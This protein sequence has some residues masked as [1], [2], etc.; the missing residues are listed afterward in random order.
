[1][2]KENFQFQ[3]EVSRLLDLVTHS[4]YSEK[5]IF[6]REL[7][8]NSSDACDKMRYIGLTDAQKLENDTQF[9]VKIILNKDDK[10]LTIS[11]N[12]IGMSRQDLIDHLGTIAQSGTAKFLETLNDSKNAVQLIGQFGVGFY[13]AFIVASEVHVHSRKAGEDKAYEWVS[14]GKGA[15]TIEEKQKTNRGTDVV[16]KLKEGEEGYLEF[17]Y[18][19]EII[20]KYSDHIAIPIVLMSDKGEEQLNK[21]SALWT[22]PKADITTEEYKEFY[23]HIAHLYDEPWDRLHFKAEG[24]IEYAALLYIPSERPMDLFHPDRKHRV[25]L[26]VKRVF[27]TDD[28]DEL[29][30][31]Y[32]RFLKGVID[33]DDLPLNISREM[34]QKNPVLAKIRQNVTK[35]V[36][37]ELQKKSENLEDYTKFWTSFGAVLK[38]GL[39]EDFSHR[40]QLLKLARF[41]SSNSADLISLDDYVASMKE[42]Q[43]EIYYLIGDNLDNLKKSPHLEGFMSQGINVLLLIDPIDDFWIPSIGFFKDKK[44][45]S[46]T[47]ANLEKNL[48]DTQK[49]ETKPENEKGLESLKIKLQ[50]ALQGKVKEVRF[51][52][53]LKES[54]SC[55]VADDNDMDIRLERLLRQHK[56]QVNE[57]QKILEINAQHPIVQNLI[58]IVDQGD[59]QILIDELAHIFYAQ[60][61]ITDGDQL[62]DPKDYVSRVN[63]LLERAIGC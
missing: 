31:S 2:T 39:Y 30:P 17:H 32:L 41:H 58:T 19:Q 63:K 56:Q 45:Q 55:L 38:E 28:C 22:R 36:L 1:M 43:N 4:L 6:L 13:S 21:A 33:S 34:L 16:L 46:I 52:H 62:S 35:K 59:K 49:D 8:S 29:I 51:S 50:L 42:G 10:T 25:K 48:F 24:M 9:K 7:I 3:A 53:R 54:I 14:D 27:I 40:E 61:V 11:D 5:D 44:L 12:G 57:A 23:H 37:D 47:K 15:Y 18:L 60:A 20:K 26:F